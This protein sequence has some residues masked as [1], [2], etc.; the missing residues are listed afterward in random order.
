MKPIVTRS[1]GGVDPFKPRALA[2]ITIGAD[3]PATAFR[4]C[5]RFAVVIMVDPIENPKTILVTKLDV[6]AAE[7]DASRY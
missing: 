6:T 5:L 1:L 4:K 7:P 3:T 2:G